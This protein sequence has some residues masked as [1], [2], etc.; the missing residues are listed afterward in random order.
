MSE[1]QEALITFNVSARQATR[2]FRKLV[3]QMQL[4]QTPKWLRPFVR[5]GFWV[6]EKLG[7]H[8]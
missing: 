5:F 8:D 4:W 1:L 7:L 3:F 6:E 2:A